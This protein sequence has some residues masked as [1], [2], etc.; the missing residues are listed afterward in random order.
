MPRLRLGGQHDQARSLVIT[1][2]PA[3]PSYHPLAYLSRL[4]DARTFQ[5][6]QQYEVREI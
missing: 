1:P 3:F 6:L 4:F 5:L 2:A